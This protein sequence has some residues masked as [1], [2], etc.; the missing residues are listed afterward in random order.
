MGETKQATERLITGDRGLNKENFTLTD[1]ISSRD[2]VA[3]KVTDYLHSIPY[4]VLARVDCLYRTALDVRVL[5][6]KA[7]NDK[8][9]KAITYRHDCVHRNGR[10]KEGNWLT[11]CT[12]AYVEEIA[13][14]M[15]SLVDRIERELRG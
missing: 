14:V 15:R 1:I 13:V 7:D 9:L 2:I 4:H 8:L 5:G 12:R 6:E 10:D 11:V 3:E